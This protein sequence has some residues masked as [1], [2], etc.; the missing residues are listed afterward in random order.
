M[1]DLVSVTSSEVNCDN[2]EYSKP[3]E[4]D[5]VIKYHNVP[6]PKCGHILI[7]DDD[8]AIHWRIKKATGMLNQLSDSFGL[9]EGDGEELVSRFTLDTAEIKERK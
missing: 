9:N 1:T 8:I 4:F 7:D 3:V 6:C 5:E 2:C